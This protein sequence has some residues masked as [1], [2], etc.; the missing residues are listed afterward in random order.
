MAIPL[1]KRPALQTDRPAAVS[2]SSL[3]IVVLHTKAKETLRALKMAGELACGL[4]PIRLLAV[5]VVPYPLALN[6]PQVSV[7]FLESRF[8]K[9]AS[10]AVVDASVDIRLGRDAGGVL[11]SALSPRSVVVIGGRRRWWPT[12][13]MRLARRLERLGH[14]VVFMNRKYSK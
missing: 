6:A 4:A 7:E 5:Q 9:M 10:E 13:R 12:A 8:S 1:T 11:E 14:H 2:D 3:E